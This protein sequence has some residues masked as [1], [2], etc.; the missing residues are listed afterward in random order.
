[1]WA[2]VQGV[3]LMALRIIAIWHQPDR[4]RRYCHTY[5]GLTWDVEDLFINGTAGCL[6]TA[7]VPPM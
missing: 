7:F 2:I 4:T 1:M 3:R 5:T 6:L